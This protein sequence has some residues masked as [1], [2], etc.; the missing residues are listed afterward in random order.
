M[1][2]FKA[3]FRDHDHISN[4]ALFRTHIFIIQSFFYEL[5]SV[6]GYRPKTFHKLPSRDKIYRSK[7]EQIFKFAKFVLLTSVSVNGGERKTLYK[8]TKTPINLA[9]NNQLKSRSE[10]ETTQI[11]K[12]IKNSRCIFKDRKIRQISWRKFFWIYH[13]IS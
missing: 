3:V 1:N 10:T 12:F 13:L 9:H 8:I 4:R 11:K 7:C 2:P 5:I 6:P